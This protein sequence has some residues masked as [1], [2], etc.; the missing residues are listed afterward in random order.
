MQTGVAQ[1]EALSKDRAWFR[2][3]QDHDVE[4][5]MYLPQAWL[6]MFTMWMPLPAVVGCLGLLEK[7]GFPAMLA[8]TVVLLDHV[9]GHLL[10]LS[11]MDSLLVALRHMKDSTPTPAR[12]CAGIYALLPAAK[13]AADEQP[14]CQRDLSV[15]R[16]GPKVKN[17]NGSDA[18][19]DISMRA[20]QMSE[21]AVS[22]GSDL[23]NLV[24]SMADAGEAGSALLRWALM[25]LSSTPDEPFSRTSPSVREM[26]FLQRPSEGSRETTVKEI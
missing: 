20:Q 12:I 21:E 11:D 3:F 4:P 17:I 6:T 22:A 2:H 23:L 18:M 9:E 7:E 19:G 8:M 5:D 13:A 16:Q 25:G 15:E 10:C 14:S 1:F 26:Q 24:P